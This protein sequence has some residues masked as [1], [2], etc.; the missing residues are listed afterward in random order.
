M[1][2]NFLLEILNVVI[3]V[4]E[5]VLD[6]YSRDFNISIKE[7]ESP[8]TEADIKVHD[9]IEPVL[10]KTGLPVLSEEGDHF[11]EEERL[12]WE[13]YWL[14]DPIDGTK[15]F[16][17][18]T[19]EFCICI[20]LIHH[21]KPVLGV[22]YA[23]ALKKLYF[24]TENLGSFL[25]YNPVNR[26][27]LNKFIQDAKI[28]PIN[29]NEL[30]QYVFLKSVSFYDEKTKEYVNDL[31]SK[32]KNF[33]EHALGSALKLAYFAEGRASEYSRL[34]SLKEWDIAAGHAICMYAGFKVV[35]F[36]SGYELEY[37]NADMNVKPFT[38]KI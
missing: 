5:E 24:S 2:D 8:V 20:A 25:I 9:I 26:N 21:K 28:L 34:S 38:V 4:G 15:E 10:L 29:T 37:N 23:P 32:H 30:N 14:I 16:V 31:K 6:I 19:G 3:D 12:N 35:E 11:T 18:K 27:S 36:D 7:D 1:Y 17:N 13:A 33:K 22:L